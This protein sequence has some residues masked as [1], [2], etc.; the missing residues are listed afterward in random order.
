MLFR[1]PVYNYLLRCVMKKMSF[2]LILIVLFA[3]LTV[4][5]DSSFAQDADISNMDNAQL[6]QLLQAIMQKLEENETDDPTV[7]LLP[8]STTEPVIAPARFQIYKNKKLIL[9]RIP[10][11]RFIR[12]DSGQEEINDPEK[13]DKEK[14]KEPPEEHYE[15][16]PCGVLF[17][18]YC[19][20]NTVL[21]CGCG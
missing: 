11:D 18:G 14:E 16:E 2:S 21:T 1:F 19:G 4:F 9:E 13:K 5:N 10:D 7:V 8:E 12:K 17:W 15:G 3:M 6:L 20:N